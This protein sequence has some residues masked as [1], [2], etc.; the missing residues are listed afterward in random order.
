MYFELLVVT[1]PSK[2]NQDLCYFELFEVSLYF[3]ISWICP[4]L[5][6]QISVH[7][8]MS[9]LTK[10]KYILQ[11]FYFTKTLPL[12][13]CSVC[14]IL[15]CPHIQGKVTLT[16]FALL[17]LHVFSFHKRQ[18]LPTFNDL[19]ES[20]LLFININY[21]YSFLSSFFLRTCLHKDIQEN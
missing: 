21:C 5:N 3:S 10:S 4:L 19:Y 16:Y 8:T 2:C 17:A 1:N 7:N 11:A 20:H 14:G 18:R 6:L 12:F 13:S 9:L 15:L